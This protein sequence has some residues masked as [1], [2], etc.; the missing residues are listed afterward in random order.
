LLSSSHQHPISDARELHD[1][2]QLLSE[3]PLSAQL[4]L[5]LSYPSRHAWLVLSGVHTSGS[6]GGKFDGTYSVSLSRED[7]GA[8]QGPVQPAISAQGSCDRT[9]SAWVVIAKAAKH[10]SNQ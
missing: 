7:S 4:R 10:G 9:V 8:S 5:K 2:L 1:A 3:T 6:G